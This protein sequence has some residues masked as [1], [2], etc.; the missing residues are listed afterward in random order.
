MTNKKKT[1]TDVQYDKEKVIMETVAWR[2]GYYRANPQRFVK[3]Y[4]GLTLKWFQQILLWVMMTYNYIMYLASRGQGKTYIVALFC[5]VR[6]ILYPGTKIVIVSG[7][8][9]QA[10]EVL[11]KVQNEF[12]RQSPNLCSEI[13]DVKIGQNGG[14]I[15]FRNGSWMATATSSDSSRGLRANIIVVDEFR[16]VDPDI[17]D[18]VIRKFLTSERH[19]K[20]LDKKEYADHVERNKEIYMSSAWFKSSWAWSKVKSYVASF[21]DDTK[22]YFICALPYQL[23]IKENLL[24][25]EQVRDEMSEA[26]FDDWKF[27]MEMEVLWQGDTG[28]S[29][30]KFDEINKRRRI[31]NALFPLWMY[32]DHNPVPKPAEVYE[33][34]LSVD[35]AL[36]ASTKKKR[37]DASAIFINDT[38]QM[39]DITLRSN[40]IYSETFEGKTTDA[41]GI[42]IMRYFYHYKCTQLV[43]DTSGIGLGVYDFIC[44]DQY[45]PETGDTYKALCACNNEEMANRCKVRDAECVV[46]TV[47]A[48]ATFNDQI[49][50]S[51]RNG[52]QNGKISFLVSD[53]ECDETLSKSVKNWNRLETRQKNELRMSYVQTTLAEYELIKLNS[54]V[55]NGKIKVKEISG[56]R[57]DRYSS[58]AYNY[59]CACQLEM[60]LKPDSTNEDIVSLLTSSIRSAKYF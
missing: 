28:D 15:T 36:M 12:M 30:F 14:C 19:P 37:N 56:M 29:F 25:K 7:A 33:R 50:T 58:I 39:D 10:N 43:L 48:D 17:L 41:L 38:V 3:D 51:L 42:I 13:E 26:T 27:E 34:I 9:K 18:T 44:K 57:K 8:L 20:Y 47:K 59:W 45:D 4:L 40:F 35:V 5:C 53:S 21:F 32:N 22:K 23:A 6:C 55:R 24:S 31:K 60:K 46:W 11:L 54:E 52:I 1:A 2:A 16:M 49:C